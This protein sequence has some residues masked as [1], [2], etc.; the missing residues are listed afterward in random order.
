MANDQMEYDPLRW[1]LD[2]IEH[3][4]GALT[5]AGLF[6]SSVS[7]KP[8]ADIGRVE[9]EAVGG[10]FVLRR[11]LDLGA[12]SEE[13]ADRN[14]I[15]TRIA[16]RPEVELDSADGL[17]RY[18]V[19]SVLFDV[20]DRSKA[21]VSLRDVA[22]ILVHSRLL[23]VDLTAPTNP[24]KDSRPV[25]WKITFT[26]D[27]Y[28]DQHAYEVRVAELGHMFLLASGLVRVPDGL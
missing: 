11:L 5:D 8:Y 10:A 4:R 17:L 2:A 18:L 15:V 6:L 3:M 22:N 9:R 26:S 25:V 7:L 19:P 21:E 12:E 23:A 20:S 13:M 1:R 27:R 14:V 24:A 28:M 16:R